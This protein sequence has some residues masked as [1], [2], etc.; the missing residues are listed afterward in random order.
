M[1]IGAFV[2]P[3]ESPERRLEVV[4]VAHRLG[5][6]QEY[7]RQLL[8]DQRLTAVRLGRR[9]RVDPVDLQTF[10]DARRVASVSPST[11]KFSCPQCG[12][13]KSKVVDSRPDTQGLRYVRW[14]RCVGCGQVFETAEEVIGRAGATAPRG[15]FVANG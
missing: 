12:D 1:S 15:V 5:M 2:P 10:I 4:H 3:A 11:D 6:G 13:W 9:W 7:V 14:R 8:R